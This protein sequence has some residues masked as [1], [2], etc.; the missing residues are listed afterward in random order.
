[1]NKITY[2]CLYST[3]SYQSQITKAILEKIF[4]DFFRLLLGAL[5][6]FIGLFAFT[7]AFASCE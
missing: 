1:M 7:P 4:F 5:C 2:A 3:E 6:L